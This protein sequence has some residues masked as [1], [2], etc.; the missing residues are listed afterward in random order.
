MGPD[1]DAQLESVRVLTEHVR[2]SAGHV[3][4]EAERRAMLNL[5]REYVSVVA[6]YRVRTQQASDLI[7]SA[8]STLKVLRRTARK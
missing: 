5:L 1:I 4:P 3:A 8:A 7:A 2:T 6:E